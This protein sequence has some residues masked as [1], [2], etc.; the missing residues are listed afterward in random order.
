M[1]SSSRAGLSLSTS[2]VQDELFLAERSH[3]FFYLFIPVSV[4]PP[5]IPASP[6]K[7]TNPKAQSVPC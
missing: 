5:P 4:I 2:A 1:R 7:Q 6:R 3:A